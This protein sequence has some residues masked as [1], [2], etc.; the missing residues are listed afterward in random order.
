MNFLPF[1]RRLRHPFFP[2]LPADPAAS[3]R[4]RSRALAGSF[5]ELSGA[6]ARGVRVSNAVYVTMAGVE[7]LSDGER[8]ELWRLF[9]VPV[10]A[11]VARGG[12]VEAWE[13][14]AQRGMHA[15]GGG[16]GIACPCGRPGV[17]ETRGAVAHAA[18]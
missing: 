13:C 18:D 14:E 7:R 11:I 6:A 12:R 10:Y 4:G 1:R 3:A 5:A 16:S 9:E 2:H 15:A 8:D 17:V